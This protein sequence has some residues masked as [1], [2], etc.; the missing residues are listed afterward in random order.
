MPLVG[1]FS[2]VSPVSRA[3][4]FRRRSILHLASLSPAFETSTFRTAQWPLL[5][6]RHWN[7]PDSST[8][9][10]A[11]VESSLR[12]A[13]GRERINK[14]FLPRGSVLPVDC[15]ILAAVKWVSVTA[16]TYGCRSRPPGER[17]VCSLK[18][19]HDQ[20]CST[21]VARPLTSRGHTSMEQ[22]DRLAA[23]DCTY[24]VG[25]PPRP[26]THSRARQGLERGHATA[27]APTRVR[28]RG[29]MVRSLQVV[30]NVCP[31][32]KGPF[33][34]QLSSGGARRGASE[35]PHPA[36]TTSPHEHLKEHPP[37]ISVTSCQE[38]EI[39]STTATE[40]RYKAQAG[41]YVAARPR[42]R[43]EG[44]IRAT[45]PRTPIASSLLRAG[46][47][48]FRRDAVLYKS[49][50]NGGFTTRLP[51]RRT[52]FDSLRGLPF[53]L[54]M[55]SCAAP[56]SPRFT[57]IGS[58]ALG[59]ESRRIVSRDWWRHVTRLRQAGPSGPAIDAR[60]IR[61]G[62]REVAGKTRRPAASYG[63]IPTCENKGVTRPGIE[64]G[65]PW[66]EAS[67]LTAWPPRSLVVF[68]S[69]FQANLLP[70]GLRWLQDAVSKR[71]P[72]CKV[73]NVNRDKAGCEVYS[74]RARD[75]MPNKNCC[76]W[77]ETPLGGF[78]GHSI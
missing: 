37:S 49:D 22:W 17:P 45:V 6:L 50:L 66:W 32:A 10:E 36:A 75:N 19:V 2:R 68:P 4:A 23:P 62:K 8:P 53:P 43:S 35:R 42:S 54:L 56:Y 39:H 27:L 40:R 78:D 60:Q 64:P 9:G 34:L 38:L 59:V 21:P 26:Q 65:S 55:H 18:A 28:G 48:A 73:A 11:S 52:G 70:C 29:S 1:G 25:C 13:A 77:G 57:L 74:A 46:R 5:A 16:S 31:V 44:A 41:D 3:L 76:V 58:Q 12:D 69:L 71:H 61:Q 20:T 30:R 47:A 15:A 7:G 33:T 72:R 14:S 67:R 51:L 24:G 63:T